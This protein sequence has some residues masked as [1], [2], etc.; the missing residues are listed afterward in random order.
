MARPRQIA[1]VQTGSRIIGFAN[2]YGISGYLPA[3]QSSR[4]VQVQAPS[5]A[6]RKAPK[7]KSKARR[8]AKSLWT[9]F[10]DQAKVTLLESSGGILSAAIDGATELT[11]NQY[12]NN[13][14]IRSGVKTGVKMLIGGL[15]K[16]NGSIA[17]ILAGA[18]GDTSGHHIREVA[19]KYGQPKS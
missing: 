1:N 18:Q 15:F 2:P 3:P 17:S 4:S 16:G 12:D 7:K 9:S 13:L 11:S 8:K 19:R 6:P 10:K 14:A 5:R